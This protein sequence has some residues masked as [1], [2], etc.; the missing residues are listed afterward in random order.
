MELVDI[1]AIESTLAP[2]STAYYAMAC[3]WWTTNPADL[4]DHPS[5]LPCCPYCGSMLMMAPA[6]DFIANARK[7]PEHYGDGGL[8]TFALG[9]H[10]SGVHAI[11]WLHFSRHAVLKF[12][13]K[14]PATEI[15][16][17]CVACGAPWSEAT[18]AKFGGTC[19]RC[20]ASGA[21]CMIADDVSVTINWH[22]LRILCMWAYAHALRC[23]SAGNPAE[24]DRM[25]PAVEAI[26][27]RLSAQHPG[28]SQLS[29]AG[30][31][32]ELQEDFPDLLI[33][34]LAVVETATRPSAEAE[35][36]EDGEPPDEE[37]PGPKPS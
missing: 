17:R 24:G 28:R 7:T 25:V 15:T 23:D 26:G 14:P 1:K 33:V 37:Q 8:D 9:H 29:M 12:P 30:E 11:D 27:G 13:A 2:D 20:G 31:L 3:C 36:E 21:P 16:M 35:D 4:G 22:E 10:S 5:G 19:P 6:S 18:V 32:A 34:G